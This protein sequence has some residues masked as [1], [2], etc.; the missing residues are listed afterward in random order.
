MTTRARTAASILTTLATAALAV[1]C[2]V[3]GGGPNGDAGTPASSAVERDEPASGTESSASLDESADSPGASFDERLLAADYESALAIYAADTT[4][5][6][7]EDATFRAALAAAMAGHP[8]HDPDRAVEL[9]NRL[10][11][12][13]P[14]TSRLFE[15]EVYLDLLARERELRAAVERLDRELQQLKAIDLGQ[16]PAGQP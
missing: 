1:G 8:A 2:S 5:H 16:A 9:F 12:R 6:S 14:D 10:L 3:F 7:N 4:L 13:H 11:E 15:V